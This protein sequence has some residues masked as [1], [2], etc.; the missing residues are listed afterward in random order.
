[1]SEST[2]VRC[3]GRGISEPAERRL[4][5]ISDR[6][7]KEGWMVM[8]TQWMKNP[9]LEVYVAPVARREAW[10]GKVGGSNL[11]F[12]QVDL[13]CSDEDLAANVGVNFYGYL[14]V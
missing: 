14:E 2:T 10:G 11:G 6:L 3:V 12:V 1:M 4:Q 5:K 8:D 13:S 7:F 9:K